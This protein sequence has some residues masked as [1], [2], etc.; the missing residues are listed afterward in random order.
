MKLWLLSSAI[1]S[2]VCLVACGPP[3]EGEAEFAK[4]ESALKLNCILTDDLSNSCGCASVLPAPS[5]PIRYSVATG[6]IDFV[7]VRLT[8]PNSYNVNFRTV[9]PAGAAP[10]DTYCTQYNDTCGAIATNDDYQN[11][12]H[13]FLGGGVIVNA[14]PVDLVFAVRPAN[15]T[16]PFFPSTGAYGI[17]V[18]ING[19]DYIP[20]VVAPG[21]FVD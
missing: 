13:C 6:D 12:P 2:T 7:R 21:E 8:T 14:S 1:V 5:T 16:W 15:K 3:E 20:P 18:T 11:G 19:H 10:I 17:V 9:T 4:S